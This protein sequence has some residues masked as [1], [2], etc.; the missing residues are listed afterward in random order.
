MMMMV[1]VMTISGVYHHLYD[2]EN[3]DE[4]ILEKATMEVREFTQSDTFNASQVFLVTWDRVRQR[5]RYYNDYDQECCYHSDWNNWETYNQII[6]DP[7]Y[8]GAALAYNPAFWSQRDLYQLEDREPH[9]VCCKQA[10]MDK[11]CRKFY[12]VRPI[13]EC[14]ANIPFRFSWMFGDPHI[15]TLDGAQYTFNGW[16]EYTMVSLTTPEVNFT[17]QGRTGLAETGN[18][19]LTNAT[20]FTAFGAE[21]NN[22]R[23]F[24]GLEPG[25]KDSMVIYASG[26]D[27][28]VQ[29]QQNADFEVE[30]DSLLLARDN[31]SLVI[32]FSSSISLSVSVG[33]K[34]LDISVTMP[35]EYQNQT[36]GL[37]GNFNGVKDDD[38]IL[39]NGTALSSNLTE[40]EVYYQFG[41]EWSV[42]DSTTVMRYGPREGHS[43]YDHPEF[44]PIFL[45]EQ[46]ADVMQ[47]AEDRCGTA[48]IACV[49][50]FIATGSAEFADA[51]R[52]TLETAEK[53]DKQSKNTIPRIEAPDNITVT[54]GSPTIIS[55]TGYDD[56]GDDITYRLADDADGSLQIDPSTGQINATLNATKPTAIR[57][58]VDGHTC[59]DVNECAEKTD[60]CEQVCNNTVEGLP[61][62]WKGE[63]CQE[64]VDECAD[65]PTVCGE[66]RV[67]ANNN[68][69]YS[70]SCREGYT[71]KANGECEAL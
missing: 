7:P 61:A 34:S 50:D 28:S 31:N 29:F 69:S 63:N 1:M 59:T 11:F 47:A 43:D 21:E 55:V 66:D 14:R 62:G 10:S 20:V 15:E 3:G 23:V 53:T 58:V 6:L 51:S 49:F 37:L 25:E 13:G 56:D 38:F 39:P 30:T 17:L 41:P 54:S 9:D 52:E 32:T 5:Y 71:Q 8:A 67:C 27:H 26:T 45:D 44:T 64:D 57:L 68:G 65:D 60:D 18:G 46:P 70:C 40:R 42:T 24:V 2:V 35:L 22:A 12:K 48:N 4:S 16:G 19:T 33:I 36:T